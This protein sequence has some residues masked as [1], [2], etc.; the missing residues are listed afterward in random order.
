MRQNHTHMKKE[1]VEEKHISIFTV[2]PEKRL[3]Q[4]FGE[5]ACTSQTGYNKEE[6]QKYSSAFPPLLSHSQKKKRSQQVAVEER[7][8]EP[9]MFLTV[10]TC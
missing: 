7:W 3:Y 4:V 6:E 10:D 2:N 9:I 8:Y 1:N 5:N